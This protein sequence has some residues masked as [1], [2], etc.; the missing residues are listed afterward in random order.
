MGAT[1][2]NQSYD[3]MSPNMRRTW[4]FVDRKPMNYDEG[5]ALYAYL[6]SDECYGEWLSQ[7]IAPNIIR[8]GFSDAPTA[9]GFKLKFG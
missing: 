1:R 5:Q 3:T 8:M 6:S 2:S 7:T 4:M 9:M